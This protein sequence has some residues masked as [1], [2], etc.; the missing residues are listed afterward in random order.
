VSASTATVA[1]V[2]FRTPGQGK[3][4]LARTDAGGPGLT[5]DQRGRLAAAMLADVVAAL[6]VSGVER[7]VVVASGPEAATSARL[8]GVETVLDP[9]GA[10]G[11]NEAVD[12]VTHHFADSSGVLVVAADLPCLE[13][14]EITRLLDSPAPVVVAPTVR[15]GT[16]GLLRRPPTLIP[17][18]YGP[19]SARRH[20][21]S[22]RDAGHRAVAFTSPGFRRDVDNWT[23]LRDL[24]GTQVGASTAEVLRELG[25]HV[26]AG[27]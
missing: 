27:P 20:L 18:A 3:T 2:P 6:T 17:A 1:L 9:P 11:L 5:P 14:E 15:G 22:A 4:R 24:S 8:L 7:I 10:D 25:D 13:A 12:A 26:A 21:A 16:G 23:D 19:Q